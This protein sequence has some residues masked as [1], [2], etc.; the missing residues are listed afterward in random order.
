MMQAPG[1][2]GES[3]PPSAP[4]CTDAPDVGISLRR[5][6]SQLGVEV[7]GQTRPDQTR[8]T[9]NVFQSQSKSYQTSQLESRISTYLMIAYS[10]LL[11]CWCGGGR[12]GKTRIPSE[13]FV[14]FMKY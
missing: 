3:G 13:L 6:A 8:P 12:V 2:E 9:K 10:S 1:S 14:W 11:P 5:P 4:W 7:S